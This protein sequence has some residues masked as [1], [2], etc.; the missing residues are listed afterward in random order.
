M[1]R[2]YQR[3]KVSRLGLFSV[4]NI[5]SLVDIT[6]LYFES[7]FT[8]DFAKPLYEPCFYKGLLI[9]TKHIYANLGS[10]RDFF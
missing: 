5:I 10:G 8:K 3:N 1:L 7:I 6:F 2:F 9:K 4:R